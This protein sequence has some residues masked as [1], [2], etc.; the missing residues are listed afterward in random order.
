MPPPSSTDYSPRLQQNL[1]QHILALLSGSADRCHLHK[2]VA[3]F[4]GLAV[5]FLKSKRSVWA[6]AARNGLNHSDIAYDCIAELFQ[7]DESGE[8]VQL[9]AYFGGLPLAAMEDGEVLGHTRRLVFAK[10]NH[11]IFR[12][13]NE[14][15]PGL[16]KILRNLKLAIHALRNF[17]EVERFGELWI[18]PTLADPLEHLPPPGQQELLEALRGSAQKN[19]KTPDLL[20]TLSMYLREQSMH[21]R[22]VSL[23]ELALALRLLFARDEGDESGEKSVENTLAAADTL[24]MVQQACRRVKVSMTP[25]YVDRGKA[26]HAVYERYF[27]V[28]EQGLVD[29]FV[30][31]DGEDFSY[32]EGLKT[33][34]PDL[35][36]EEY[37]KLYKS[38]MEYLGRCALKETLRT[39]KK[40]L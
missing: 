24:A 2:V 21:A 30:G 23:M 33:H 34:I 18:R 4:H 11:G 28:I 26:T 3:V 31:G 7:Q 19:T 37:K 20:A 39:L 25:R 8:Y 22:S 5:A 9:K 36:R 38:H 14:Y 6:L 15:D 10:T 1:Q 29:R 40:E 17:E 13:C 12:I 16:G 32:Y 27:A 35:T